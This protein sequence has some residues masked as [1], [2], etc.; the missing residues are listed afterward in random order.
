[1]QGHYSTAQA[2]EQRHAIAK[3]ISLVARTIA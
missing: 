1:M 3:V 2:D